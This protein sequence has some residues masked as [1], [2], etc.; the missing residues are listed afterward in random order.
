MQCPSSFVFV[1]LIISALYWTSEALRCREVCF[2]KCLK[3]LTQLIEG[4]YQF[5]IHNGTESEE[6]EYCLKMVEACLEDAFE[7]CEE[8][9]HVMAAMSVS[10]FNRM[11]EGCSSDTDSKKVYT[12][13][14]PC[15]ENNSEVLENCL[16]KNML[17]REKLVHPVHK[18]V[19][20]CTD[21]KSMMCIA[22]KSQEMCD[23]EISL[24][25]AAMKFSLNDSYNE[26]CSGSVGFSHN[27]WVHITSV[28]ATLLLI[29]RMK[30]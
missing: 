9:H 11:N 26:M 30:H 7:D 19:S 1:L 20:V 15:L 4:D 23:S 2:R 16:E 10:L 21:M 6:A 5:Q 25:S 24:L 13:M 18:L 28:L 3:T 29:N 8:D 17:R 12:D 14:F 22:E 27:V